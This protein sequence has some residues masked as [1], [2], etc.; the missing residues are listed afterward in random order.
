VAYFQEK[1]FRVLPSSWRNKEV[2][3]A[4][5]KEARRGATERM[6]GHVC[7]T[8]VSAQQLCRAMLD[9]AQ[10]P[11]EKPKAKS[12]RGGAQDIVE[13]LKACMEEL[14]PD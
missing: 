2:A 3:L 5:L 12:R 7:T 8:W 11:V 1:G 13:A 9:E 6:I 10:E 14:K 4:L